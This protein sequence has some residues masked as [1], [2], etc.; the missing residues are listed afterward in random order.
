MGTILEPSNFS[1]LWVYKA[2]LGKV[3][4]LTTWRLWLWPPA[5]GGGGSS[6]F[7]TYKSSKGVGG[8]EYTKAIVPNGLQEPGL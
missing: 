1:G 6:K 4:A 5:P 2:S 3:L 8:G 7:F